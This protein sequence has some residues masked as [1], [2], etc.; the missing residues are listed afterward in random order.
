MIRS[1]LLRILLARIIVTRQQ[2][3]IFN[4]SLHNIDPTLRLTLLRRLCSK[5]EPWSV[6]FVSN[7]PEVGHLVERRIVLE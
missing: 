1:Q 7:D 6:V 4:G 3:L 2:L 5:E